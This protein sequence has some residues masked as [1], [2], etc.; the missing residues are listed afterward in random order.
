MRYISRVFCCLF[1]YLFACLFWYDKHSDILEYWADYVIMS[2]RIC[3]L[4]YFSEEY[5]FILAR[6]QLIQNQIENCLT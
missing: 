1:A 2:Q 4:L 3:S 5:Y 6:Q